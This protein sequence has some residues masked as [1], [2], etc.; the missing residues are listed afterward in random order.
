LTSF[1]VPFDRV[2]MGEEKLALTCKLDEL[3]DLVGALLVMFSQLVFFLYGHYNYLSLVTRCDIGGHPTLYSNKHDIGY[4]N[5][6]RPVPVATR[7]HRARK[8]TGKQKYVRYSMGMRK[9]H[10]DGNIP[11]RK[12]RIFTEITSE[13]E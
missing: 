13:D 7:R 6:T 4:R 11:K 3:R 9:A 8:Q 12:D 10:G 2:T 1:E 5:K